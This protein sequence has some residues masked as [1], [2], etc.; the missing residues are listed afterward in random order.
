MNMNTKKYP[1][2]LYVFTYMQNLKS[3][4][5]NKY[6]KRNRVQRTDEWL[7]EGREWEEGQQG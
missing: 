1:R 4:Q 5:M 7:Q 6:N 2:I 3:K